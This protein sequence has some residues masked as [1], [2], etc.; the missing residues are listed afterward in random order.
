MN[1]ELRN[2]LA[3]KARRHYSI[4][5]QSSRA[6]C[7]GSE[8]QIHPRDSSLLVVIAL[9]CDTLLPQDVIETGDNDLFWVACYYPKQ[10][11][12]DW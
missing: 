7:N 3:R 5:G 11:Q 10:N 4:A 2:K 12:E 9:D 6:M 8:Q 1:H